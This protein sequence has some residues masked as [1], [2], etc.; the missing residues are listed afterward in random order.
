[1]LGQIRG[2]RGGGMAIVVLVLWLL[3]AGAWALVSLV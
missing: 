2:G 1:V 3:T